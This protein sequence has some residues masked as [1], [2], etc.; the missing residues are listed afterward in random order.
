MKSFDKLNEKKVKLATDICKALKEDR[1][2][3]AMKLFD[4]RDELMLDKFKEFHN[5]YVAKNDAV[6]LE[7][8]GISQFTSEEL[9]SAD[10]I[11]KTAK[12]TTAVGGGGVSIDTAALPNTFISRL[13]N[14]IRQESK[15]I[16]ACRV[17]NIGWIATMPLDNT[18]DDPATWTGMGESMSET[19]A[20]IDTI[21]TM[22][23]KLGKILYVPNEM[24]DMGA[25]WILGYLKD[26]LKYCFRLGMEMSIASGTGANGPIGMSMTK[27]KGTD[28]SK[29][30]YKKDAIK[31]TEINQV[32]YPALVDELTY[33]SNGRARAIE[34]VIFIVHPSTLLRK[35]IPAT[36]TRNNN[37]DF[38]SMAFPFPTEVIT[39]VAI[40]E[41]EAIIGIPNKYEF[42]I[43]T[44]ASKDGKIVSD[45]SIK[46][47]EHM[48]GLKIFMYGNGSF[49]DENDFKLLDV[50]ELKEYIPKFQLVEAAA[51]DDVN[52]PGSEG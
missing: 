47:P 46:F 32:E 13:L 35:I 4:E 48:T 1:I 9:K 25:A 15:L 51:E 20:V 18:E 27:L 30:Y 36:V 43:G 16:N 41:N 8:A 45:S 42:F 2:E 10:E 14:E 52:T 44:G 49:V 33:D 26:K 39:S 19:Q 22:S 5:E 23:F 34:K 50:S 29:A 3:D 17:T 24:L 11:I 38:S 28:A 12:E 6:I 7:K 40:D 21:S 31:L 37:G